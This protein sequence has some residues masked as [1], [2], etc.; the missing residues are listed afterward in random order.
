MLRNATSGPMADDSPFSRLVWLACEDLRTPLATVSGYAR[1]LAR[2]SGLDET[3]AGYVETLRSASEQALELLD[4]LTL[5]TRIE[6]GRYQ[7]KVADAESA[8]LARA[9]ADRLGP[10]RVA[11]SGPGGRV[12]VDRGPT[13]RAISALVQSALR[14]GGLEEVAVVAAGAELRVSPI[15]ASSAP[16]VVGEDLRDLGAAVAVRVIVAQGGELSLDGET[17]TIRLPT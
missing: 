13:E 6:T 12:L 11:V 9:A 1:T 4:E 14:H 3:S 17:L 8:E 10:E 16:V 2:A 15:V 7:P 5:A